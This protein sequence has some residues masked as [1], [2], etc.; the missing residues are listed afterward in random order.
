MSYSS[1]QKSIGKGF[2]LTKE[3][4]GLT[5]YSSLDACK[6]IL[7][8]V[9]VIEVSENMVRCFQE[10]RNVN[11]PLHNGRNSMIIDIHTA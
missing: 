11:V 1:Y 10:G 8:P 7:V 9:K 4:E 2:L 5:F 6:G 3:S